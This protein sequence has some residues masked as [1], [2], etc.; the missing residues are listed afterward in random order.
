MTCQIANAECWGKV[1]VERGVRLCL[2]HNARLQGRGWKWFEKREGCAL[3]ELRTELRKELE[4][5][6]K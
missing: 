2:T 5:E 6:E 3:K 1:I 4:L